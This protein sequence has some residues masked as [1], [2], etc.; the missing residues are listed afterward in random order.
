MSKTDKKNKKSKHYIDNDEFLSA[1]NDWKDIVNSCRKNGKPLPPVTDYIGL[2]FYQ[3]ADRLSRRP[4]FINYPFREDMVSDG[5][6]NCLQYAHNFDHEKSEN[7][8][9]YF[10]QIIYYAFLRRIEKEK[11]QAYIKFKCMER[12]DIDQRYT[13]W[14]K[15]SE[16]SGTFTEFIQRNFYLSEHDLEKLD[17]ETNKPNKRKRKKK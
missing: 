15:E 6:E 1:M 17:K 12:A 10:T 4:N 7:P 2:C 8:F 11:K 14:L 3:I 13:E 16:E 5:V 9:S